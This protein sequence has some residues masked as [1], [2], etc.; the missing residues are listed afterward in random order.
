MAEDIW[1]NLPYPTPHQSVFEAGWVQVEDHWKQPELAKTWQTLRQ[2]R[3][4]VNQVLEKARQDK[5][6]G[7][8]LEAKVLLYVEDISLRQALG[9][10]NPGRSV[11]TV[12][13][14]T[15]VANPPEEATV[16]PIANT[17]E[18]TTQ[19]TTATPPSREDIPQ[20]QELLN[21]ALAVMAEL[22]RY[23][24]L[25]FADYRR[26]LLS[27][28]LIVSGTVSLIVLGAI[29]DAI[30]DFP[31]LPGLLE[32]IGIGYSGWFVNRYVLRANNRKELTDTVASVSNYVIGKT[33]TDAAIDALEAFEEAMEEAIGHHPATVTSPT[34]V[35][36]VP[37]PIGNGVDELRYLF[38]TSQVEVLDNPQPLEA[39]KYT[40][41][42]NGW[43]IGVV[44]AEGQ[45]C[46]RC[47]NY[48]THVGES[49]E[50]P[51]ICDRCVAAL[52]GEF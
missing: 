12:P 1:Q 9:K 20:W 10:M 8:S 43:K 31:L 17:P 19:E 50:D 15:T 24:G 29:V 30:A 16:T 33:Q 25:F 47:W 32:L 41:Q 22:P 42:V 26:P 35:V 13:T 21:A 52:A 49:E 36:P 4:E 46:D 28:G 5:A 23:V 38:I 14:T 2:L 3:G 39:L 37:Q 51:T 7:S 45:K 11:G 40:A 18:E 44:D 27:L 48:S 6:V 34:P